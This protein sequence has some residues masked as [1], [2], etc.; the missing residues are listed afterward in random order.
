MYIIPNR[1]KH[2]NGIDVARF[3]QLLKETKHDYCQHNIDILVSFPH[4]VATQSSMTY[5]GV[6]NEINYGYPVVGIHI[7]DW[8]DGKAVTLG[9]WFS[10][11]TTQDLAV[12]L[13]RKIDFQEQD[14]EESIN[15]FLA[16]TG[17]F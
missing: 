8:I 9:E 5:I 6:Q 4:G 16:G 1:K 10:A 15:G 3:E 2:S 13:F 11:N 14:Y 17:R 12:E 7:Y